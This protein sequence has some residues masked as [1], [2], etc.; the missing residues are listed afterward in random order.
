MKASIII[1]AFNSRERLYYNLLSLNNQDCSFSDFEVIVVDNGSNDN[2][3]DMVKKFKKMAK[4]KL[5]FKRLKEN[6][7][8]ARGRNA[9]IKMA[10]GDIL[11]FHDSDMIA[12]KDFVRRHLKHHEEK[13]VVVCGISWKRIITFYY[14]ELENKDK[15]Y[16]GLKY[17]KAAYLK[18]D[19]LPVLNQYLI[20]SGLYK[21]YIFDLNGDFIDEV[22]GILK[23]YG[24]DL[25]NYALPWRLFITNNASAE[26]EKVIQVGMFDESIIGYGFEDY[27]LGIR[28]YKSGGRFIFDENIMNVHQEHPSNIKFNEFNENIKYMCEKYNNIYFIDVILVCISYLT[29]IDK[30]FINELVIDINK[31]LESG[32][33]NSI[34]NI[35]L[36]LLQFQRK[37]NFNE[38]LE[39]SLL[40]ISNINLEDL[41]EE[42]NILENVFDFK[43][44]ARAMSAL[45]NDVYR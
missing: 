38:D 3:A 35:F 24:N 39:S 45:I 18:I 37:K 22:K 33:Y 44:F 10:Q 26:R 30:S 36:I 5:K 1:P 16:Q 32:L 4:F 42:I 12:P 15:D 23:K 21:N 8:I 41:I 25:K 27:D 9:A 43:F 11:I 31:M 13:N 2:T 19:K 20:M 29:S 7:G 14:K 28:L 40:Y 34:L 17:L 6:R